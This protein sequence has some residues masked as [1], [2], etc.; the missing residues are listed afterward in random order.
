MIIQQQ[1]Q[2]QLYANEIPKNRKTQT[3][4]QQKQLETTA[5]GQKDVSKAKPFLSSV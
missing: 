3:N 2:Q 5:E 4:K 1:Q